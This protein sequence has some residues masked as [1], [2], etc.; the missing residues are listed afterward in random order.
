MTETVGFDG[1][2][3]FIGVVEDIDD[4]L[5]LGRCR[6]RINNLHSSDKD[7]LPTEDLPF[8]TPVQDITSAAIVE[9]GRSPTGLL[10]GSTVI[11][12]FADGQDAQQPMIMGT[13]AGNPSYPDNTLHEVNKLARGENKLA[14]TKAALGSSPNPLIREPASPYAAVYPNNHVTET[15]SGH[16]IEFDDTPNAE[17]IHIYHKSGSF[18]EM[19]PNG[20]VV[21]HTKNGWKT[22]T[23][24]EKIHIKG[25]MDIYVDGDVKWVVK[26]NYTSLI[27]KNRTAAIV[28]DY[29]YTVGGNRHLNIK[30]NYVAKM[31]ASGMH[32][33][34][35]WFNIES[36]RIDMNKGA[37]T[38]LVGG[39]LKNI[40]TRAA[41][42]AFSAIHGAHAAVG[43][44]GAEIEMISTDVG[45]YV[46]DAVGGQWINPDTGLV[47][48]IYKDG[49]ALLT[50]G[51]AKMA[52]QLG[53]A[54]SAL[55]QD[56]IDN[57]M[58]FINASGRPELKFFDEVVNMVSKGFDNTF[59]LLT[60]GI[61]P[62]T[63]TPGFY[64]DAL[65]PIIEQNLYG[66]R[67]SSFGVNDLIN[68]A[69]GGMDVV[70]AA[71]GGNI[72]GAVESATD[73]LTPPGA[74]NELRAAVGTLTDL[75]RAATAIKGGQT[76]SGAMSAIN[77]IDRISGNVMQTEVTA[78][79]DPDTGKVVHAVT[80]R[81]VLNTVEAIAA[82]QNKQYDKALDISQLVLRGQ[83]NEAADLVNKGIS[84]TQIVTNA[85]S[86]DTIRL[87]TTNTGDIIHTLLKTG[88]KRAEE[89]RERGE[90]V[91]IYNPTTDSYE[92]WE[93]AQE[94]EDY[95]GG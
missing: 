11:G 62:G 87:S 55:S 61:A 91:K 89:A 1:F 35:S 65:D 30:K 4:P 66:Q 95:E 75:G 42:N 54:G 38:S 77:T 80:G 39:V 82:A 49:A 59:S 28:L 29:D 43:G 40:A 21:T 73:L 76:F 90:E 22:V 25:N 24:N 27:G 41:V 94:R 85:R 83:S 57:V 37:G 68:L 48:T 67:A 2:Y 19:H 31:G 71:K 69:V 74:G 26:G 47:S 12:F 17:R 10:V 84:A 60:P 51:A 15:T 16:V 50:D 45:D 5:Q 44:V 3:W 7:L 18:V 13:F 36:R 63:R 53:Y 23:G 33:A 52:Q 92:Y 81:D 72:F 86:G 34:A 64:Q 70:N 58:P 46:P 79:K 93:S 56:A 8:A 9:K 6:I 32:H 78:W 88:A 14:A 20:D